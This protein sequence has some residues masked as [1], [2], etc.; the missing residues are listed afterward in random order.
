GWDVSAVTDM[1]SMF[2]FAVNFNGNLNAWDVSSVT[3]MDSMFSAAM[4]FDGDVRD[5]NVSAVTDMS[6]MFHGAVSFSGV[7]G[8]W[9]VGSVTNMDEM[10]SSAR[11]FIGDLKS[12]NVSSVTS[13]SKMFY[14]ALRFNSD[15]SSWDVGSVTD[16]E[17]MFYKAFKFDSDI[18]AWD[19]SRVAN[20]RGMSEQADSFDQDLSAWQ[21]NSDSNIDGIFSKS[22]MSILN[23]FRV[24]RSWNHPNTAKEARCAEIYLL[25]SSPAL[26]VLL[27][28]AVVKLRLFARG[29]DGLGYVG[30]AL[31]RSA[32][33]NPRPALPWTQEQQP[34]QQRVVAA[35]VLSYDVFLTHDWG[36]DELGRDNHE[37][38]KQ[39]NDF[40]KS[41]GKTTWFDED[42]LTHDITQQIARGIE[43]SN[44]VAVFITQRYME[45]LETDEEDYCREEFQAACNIAGARNMIGVVME[46]RMLDQRRWRGPLQ[47][48]MGSR[49]FVDFST[50]E[51]MHANGAN[52]GTRSG[53]QNNNLKKKADSHA[54]E[55]EERRGEEVQGS[56]GRFCVQRGAMPP[57]VLEWVQHDVL[58]SCQPDSP[59]LGDPAVD[60]P[61]LPGH[62]YNEAYRVHQHAGV[63][64]PRKTIHPRF[65]TQIVKD[66]TTPRLSAWLSAFKEVNAEWI[67]E[68]TRKLMAQAPHMGDLASKGR[69]FSDCS[70]QVHRG[71]QVTGDNLGWHIDTLNSILHMALSIR[72]TRTLHVQGIKDD[73]AAHKYEETAG[74]F[75]V[76][77]PCTAMHA[78]EY[79]S[80]DWDH[81]II[82][83]QCR[84]LFTSEEL[85]TLLL[86]KSVLFDPAR[87]VVAQ[88]ILDNPLASPTMADV[89]KHFSTG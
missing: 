24:C 87:D 49:L 55:M 32:C 58:F 3:K 83:V 46:P 41:Q 59:L 14:A 19:V 26:V 20:F 56:R 2:F 89:L 15:L 33:S 4:R 50:D 67:A 85:D 81:R 17:S 82:A 31:A 71:D 57:D 53:E 36:S 63:E 42:R 39:V 45:K 88:H 65:G 28:V 38:V 11:E 9:D 1:S 52:L 76:S 44:K 79:P 43:L 60:Y 74:N 61:T 35:A 73:D 72:G 30:S 27:A 75:Y 22:G 47:L 77:N 70:V 69:F 51:A 86:N 66:R 48:K 34:Q 25:F 84:V 29:R 21:V 12:W 64:L 13:M 40:L 8:A 16:M 7:V 80:T 23:K 68:L 62:E 10:F 18:G 6:S 54:I 37:R 5:W 78:V